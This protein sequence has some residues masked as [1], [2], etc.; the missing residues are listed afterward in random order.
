MSSDICKC[1]QGM[2]HWA[3][4]AEETISMASS[5]HLTLWVLIHLFYMGSSQQ[6]LKNPDI[7]IHK[8]NWF[9]NYL[10]TCEFPRLFLE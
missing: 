1:L 8:S 4:K 2:R 3:Q 5:P 7:S 10:L 6:Q 9:K